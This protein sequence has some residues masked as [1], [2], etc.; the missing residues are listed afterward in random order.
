MKDSKEIFFLVL[1]FHLGKKLFP[2]FAGGATRFR[3][4]KS[5]IKSK[6]QKKFR[7]E[8]RLETQ[9]TRAPQLFSATDDRVTSLE[10]G[11][12]V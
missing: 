6:T 4:F 2:C 8:M 11:E 12:I 7:E 1:S 3:K 9:M 10:S 5:L